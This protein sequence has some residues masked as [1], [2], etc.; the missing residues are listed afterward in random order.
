M[1]VRAYLVL[2]RDGR[3]QDKRLKHQDGACHSNVK[4]TKIITASVWE[5][6]G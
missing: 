6:Q 2:T 3:P 5:T 1:G 4:A